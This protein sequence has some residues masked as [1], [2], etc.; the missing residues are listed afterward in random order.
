MHCQRQY[1]SDG[2]LRRAE[3][4]RELPHPGCLIQQ[5][6]ETGEN[7]TGND[8]QEYVHTRIIDII[9]RIRKITIL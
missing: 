8:A 7:K 9:I 2:E 1:G 6:G 3:N 5:G 4:Q